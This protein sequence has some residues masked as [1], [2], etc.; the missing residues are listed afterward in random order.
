LE[1]K[2]IQRRS[3]QLEF[4]ESC[5]LWTLAREVMPY[6]KVARPRATLASAAAEDWGSWRRRFQQLERPPSG[7]GA[8]GWCAE[9]APQAAT[10]ACASASGLH[11]LIEFT[12]AILQAPSEQPSPKRENPA[13]GLRGDQPAAAFLRLEA[14]QEALRAVPIL[15]GNEAQA[16]FD[17]RVWWP[18][19]RV[20]VL[21]VGDS[22]GAN[23]L[24][25]IDADYARPAFE[26]I[27]RG[28]TSFEATL[29]QWGIREKLPFAALIERDLENKKD[30]KLLSLVKE[31]QLGP[32]AI[33]GLLEQALWAAY[34]SK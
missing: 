18:R 24:L 28:R 6:S 14:L 16:R 22:F 9:L 26:L 25:Q 8:C 12:T 3:T 15:D 19:T 10:C 4:E 31:K 33:E 21:V 32:I 30:P 29:K 1:R 23:L 5:A 34:Q 17:A 20:H 27:L 11:A 7:A 13:V 2:Q